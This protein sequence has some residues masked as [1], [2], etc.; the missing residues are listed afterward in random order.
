MSVH[1]RDFSKAKRVVIKVG[2]SLLRKSDNSVDIGC[3][4]AL[5]A[6]VAHLGHSQGRQVV[7]V[8]SGAVGFG[9]MRLHM[10][11]RPADV[12]TLQAAAAIGQPE[13]MRAWSEV[14][15]GHDILVSQLLLTNDGLQDRARFLNARKALSRLLDL[16]VI[17]IV[18]ENDTVA[19]EELTFGDNDSLS[20]LVAAMID[21]DLLIN[22]TN[23]D[24]FFI[25]GQSAAQGPVSTVVDIRPEWISGAASH[26]RAGR[27]FT[28]GGMA[29]KLRAASKIA[30]KAGVPVVIA[31]GRT[32]HILR[33]ILAGDSIGTLFLPPA[34]NLKGKKVWLSFFPSPAGSI[35][36]DRGAGQ[37]ICRNGKS[38]LASGIVRSEGRFGRRSCISVMTEDGR[39]IARGISFY[40]ADE[41]TRIAGRPSAAIRETL[42]LSDRTEAPAEVI[43]RNNLAVLS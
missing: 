38:L 26:E 20:A 1:V 14:F 3:L 24:G 28:L 40:S 29:A 23:V 12:A 13:L 8:S 42:G 16:R 17:P 37:A 25:P 39:E 31:N 34:G 6:D 22:L 33:S 18:N 4:R 21:A 41:I 2:T 30:L 5:S 43:H 27:G 11:R 9:M 35:V 15:E 10:T 36:V 7:I 19:V 32:R